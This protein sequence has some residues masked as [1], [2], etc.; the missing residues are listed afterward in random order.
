[1]LYLNRPPEH[2]FRNWKRGSAVSF[3]GIFVSIFGIVS[4]QCCSFFS[5]VHENKEGKL[6]CNMAGAREEEEKTI[7]KI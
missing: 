1:V 6:E 3:L 4:L 7:N 5:P 2:E